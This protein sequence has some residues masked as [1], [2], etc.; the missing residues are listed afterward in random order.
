MKTILIT[1]GAGFIG[2]NFI[3]YF[4]EKHQDVVVVNLDKLTY[5]AS[6]DNLRETEGNERYKLVQG[7]IRNAE[8][9]RYLFREFD[10]SGV[11][12]FAAESHVD[13]S[14]AGPA[15]FVETNVNGTFSLLEAARFHWMESPQV[16]RDGCRG[17]RFHHI[18]TD[19]VYGSL[20]ASRQIHRRVSL[21]P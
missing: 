19:E 13:N 12:H 2:F 9:L 7:D 5:A 15:I 3:L 10:F 1:G 17:K 21:R 4:L 16:Y 11:I 18:S 14:I 6:P 8:L 20:G